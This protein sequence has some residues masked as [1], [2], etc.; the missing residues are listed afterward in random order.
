MY[1]TISTVGNEGYRALYACLKD[2][3]FK[4]VADGLRKR[5]TRR[6]GDTMV[7]I[8]DQKKII[9][10]YFGPVE[11]PVQVTRANITP[12]AT[13]A[14]KIARDCVRI[15]HAEDHTSRLVNIDDLVDDTE[16]T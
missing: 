2:S 16:R 4:P 15:N 9:N 6:H 8:D 10:V 14:L 5:G 3:G 7:Q 12:Q 1:I 13:D 11:Y